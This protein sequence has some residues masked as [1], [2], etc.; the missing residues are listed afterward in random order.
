MSRV[1]CLVQLHAA[2]RTRSKA[3]RA[4]GAEAKPLTFT[5][6]ERAPVGLAAHK[7]IVDTL[8]KHATRSTVIDDAHSAEAFAADVIFVDQLG[9]EAAT[10]I[11]AVLAERRAMAL[12]AEKDGPGNDI[13]AKRLDRIFEQEM[14]WLAIRNLLA[15]ALPR[16]A[17]PPAK[18]RKPQRRALV[19]VDG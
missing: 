2:K 14:E 5:V 13:L 10:S 16:A 11:A 19:L 15:A 8:R 18:R 9:G 3:A 1:L 4:G 17:A 12:A 6:L 7:P